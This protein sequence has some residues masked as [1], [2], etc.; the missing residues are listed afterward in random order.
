MNLIWEK[1]GAEHSGCD[2]VICP[3]V[4]GKAFGPGRAELALR[5]AGRRQL[6]SGKAGET[7][8]LPLEEGGNLDYILVGLGEQPSPEQ[9]RAGYAAAVKKAKKLKASSVWAAAAEGFGPEQAGAAVEALVLA[10]YSFCKYRSG[11]KE[12]ACVY[13]V[14]TSAGNED[15]CREAETLAL[16]ACAARDM[17]NEPSNVMTPARLAEYA[18]ECGR[19]GG[20]EVEVLRQPEIEAL[21]ME[22]FLAVARGSAKEPRLI[23]MRYRGNPGGETLG[24]V[25][26]GLT[27]DSGGYS[28][29]PSDSMATMQSDMAGAAAVIA[30]MSAAAQRGLKVN[31]TGVVAACENALS[32]C[33]YHPGDVISS[34]SGKFIE[35]ANTDAEGR[36]TLADA[37]SYAIRGEYAARVVDI[38]TLTGAA[39][40]ALGSEIIAAMADDEGLWERAQRAA[41][42][43]GEKIWRMPCDEELAKKN[44]SEVAHIKNVGGKGAGMIT[45]GLFIRDFADGTPWMHLDIAGPS[46]ADK[47]SDLCPKGGTG[48]GVRL[49]YRLAQ[50]FEKR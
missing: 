15:A 35:V 9:I 1:A 39:I 24:L 47:A 41:V 43:A 50:S 25:G 40:V 26:K 31:L 20:F 6:F 8:S 7:I 17:V 19:R 37:V 5:L 21:G 23:V 2:V 18:S 34:Y 46:W 11:E 36:L 33:A 32:G 12:P 42:Q 49:L 45:G 16:A 30:A 13:H 27:Y 48:C 29:K 3:V 14:E 22:A 10:D 4:G 38:A 28:L 44:K